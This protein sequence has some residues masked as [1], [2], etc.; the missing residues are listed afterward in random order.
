MGNGL[1]SQQSE[2]ANTAAELNV[3]ISNTQVQLKEQEKKLVDQST[4]DFNLVKG[5]IKDLENQS[6]V[7]HQKI[8]E[9]D[10]GAQGLLEKLLG[11]EAGTN[12]KINQLNNKE[13][14]LETEIKKIKSDNDASSDGFKQELVGRLGEMKEDYLAVT[15]SVRT[16]THTLS[17]SLQE[18]KSQQISI[19]KRVTEIDSGNQ[20]LLEK[21]LAVEQDLEGKVQGINSSSGNLSDKISSLEDNT[22]AHAQSLVTIQE[23]IAIQVNDMKTVESERQ[24]AAVK[25]KEDLDAT[26]AANT[27]AISDMKDQF[28]SCH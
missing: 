15:N 8:S 6:G 2:A 10:T 9:L 12:D 11:L 26:T 16:E 21:I 20:Q 17:Q 3:L 28:S 19:E 23:S 14:E 13:K 7:C 5:Q 4:T 25:V 1:A 24:N 18:Y 22:R 27:K